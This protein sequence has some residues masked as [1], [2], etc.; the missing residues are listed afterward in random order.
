MARE[1]RETTETS[2]ARNKTAPLNHA[3][4]PPG[5]A[6]D[7]AVAS[8]MRHCE[9]GMHSSIGSDAGSDASSVGGAQEA[10]GGAAVPFA[11]HPESLLTEGELQLESDHFE[12]IVAAFASYA[13]DAE[14]TLA[15]CQRDVRALPLH[16]RRSLLP[17]AYLD[18]VAAAQRCIAANQAFYHAVIRPH[19]EARED[20]GEEGGAPAASARR[21]PIVALTATESENLA[22]L[23]RQVAREWSDEVGPAPPPR[24]S[25]LIAPPP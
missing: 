21:S 16:Q 6:E 14:R 24:R 5:L 9:G 11:L 23:L 4:A 12:R 8:A 13:G 1:A 20:D 7:G 25:P 10:R 19:C 18:R 17:Q 3:K 2:Q 15:K 22:S